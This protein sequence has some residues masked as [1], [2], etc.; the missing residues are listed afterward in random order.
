MAAYTI[1]AV[2]PIHNTGSD[3]GTRAA[4]IYKFIVSSNIPS[5][6][7]A[8]RN[9]HRDLGTHEEIM[10]VKEGMHKLYY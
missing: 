2:C 7:T 9:S 6:C 8:H 4:G 3:R 10:V 1:A 5:I